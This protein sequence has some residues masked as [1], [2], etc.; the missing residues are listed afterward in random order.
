[1]KRFAALSLIIILLIQMAGC[2]SFPNNT[3]S[4][5]EKSDPV[6]GDIWVYGKKVIETS[7]YLEDQ[8]AEIPLLKT[9][10]LLGYACEWDD[11]NIA[12]FLVWGYFIYCVDFHLEKLYLYWDPSHNYLNHESGPHAYHFLT[13]EV[14]VSDHMFSEI[15]SQFQIPVIISV[16]YQNRKVIIDSDQRQGKIVVNGQELEQTCV[17]HTEAHYVVE[18]PFLKVI[19]A[20]GCEIEMRDDMSQASFII[21]GHQCILDFLNQTLY[22]TSSSE[23]LL[24]PMP[25]SY[26]RAVSFLY[27]DVVVD[28]DTFWQILH[29]VGY[30]PDEF[31]FQIDYT[32]AVITF[33]LQ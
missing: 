22:S 1:M 21:N 5:T 19:E 28:D 29:E 2:G 12:S 17:I 25:G 24:F 16:D 31:K 3:E 30:K 23:D 32:N 14:M 26:R 13:N 6:S 7:F 33:Q 18:I 9:L 4:Q 11:S 15:C 8:Y 10:D 20:I 27:D